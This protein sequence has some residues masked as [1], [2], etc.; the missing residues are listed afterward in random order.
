ME[1]NLSNSTIIT[2]V[3]RAITEMEVDPNAKSCLRASF[4]T[5]RVSTITVR[6]STTSSS[7]LIP[8]YVGSLVVEASIS[9]SPSK[10]AFSEDFCD[11]DKVSWVTSN[12]DVNEI[13]IILKEF[14]GSIG[15]CPLAS[16]ALHSFLVSSS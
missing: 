16:Y 13:R 5:A 3:T 12:C 10:S 1:G 9:S 4:V 11:P 7:F 15:L 2:S 14:D 6:V 8:T